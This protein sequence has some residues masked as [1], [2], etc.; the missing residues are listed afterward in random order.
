M[1]DILTVARKELIEIWKARGTLRARLLSFLPMFL[2]FGIYLP[3]QQRELWLQNPTTSGIW[4]I[5]LPL[6]L[7][8]GTAAD[9]FAGE[10]ERHTLETLLA[11]RLSDRDILL[12]KVLA[13]V[14]YSTGMVWVS[15][16][17]GLVTVN[18]SRGGEGLFV[19]DSA[20]LI[21]IVVGSAMV[22][23]CMASIG[24]LVSLRAATVRAAT[25]V[26]SLITLGL[27]LGGPV[28]L[29]MLPAATQTAV[30]NALATANWAQVGVSAGSIL[31]VLNIA[32]LSLG[33]SRFR[34]A[35]LILE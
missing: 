2:V 11:T 32:L 34:R 3:W 25:Q 30:E 22:S 14:L 16:L 1:Q 18:V 23:W 4:F 13:T 26:F 6:F 20:A 29:Q 5:M 27:F 21:L 15:A 8:G 12:G 33:L 19:Y 28:L 9:S 17:L 10:R 24:V 31:M 35:R 7:A